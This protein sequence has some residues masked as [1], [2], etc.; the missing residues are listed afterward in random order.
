MKNFIKL[1][2]SCLVVILSFFIC[3][4]NAKLGI[5]F[6]GQGV[7]I[8]GIVNDFIEKIPEISNEY[9]KLKQLINV[10]DDEI[11]TGKDID[12]FTN[13]KAQASLV[14]VQSLIF[15]AINILTPG[16]HFDCV[17]GQSLGNYTAL[18]AAGGI[19]L[20]E[21]LAFIKMRDKLSI[22][23]SKKSQK[24]YS[25][26]VLKNIDMN[27]L[28]QYVNNQ[29][30]FIAGLNTPS[31][32]TVS[33]LKNEI[34]IVKAKLQKNIPGIWVLELNTATPFHTPL[35]LE[36]VEKLWK[37]FPIRHKLKKTIISD[38]TGHEHNSIDDFDKGWLRYQLTSSMK[39]SGEDGVCNK[40]KKRKLTHLIIV[41]DGQGLANMLKENIS[42]INV[43]I[44]NTVDQLHKFANDIKTYNS[45][46]SKITRLFRIH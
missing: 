8:N 38:A 4:D 43:Y 3:F 20:N 36:L 40:I 22:D 16:L 13:G 18:F 41:G 11:L 7:K 30:I 27:T 14:V 23:L 35:M 25:M 10:T 45:I 34:Q 12:L 42:D 6:T 15:K 26:L 24:L 32:F 5:C 39:W 19:E 33:G 9:T 29:T 46:K 31:C 44:I 1:M 37:V 2:I 17:V 21:L 28:R